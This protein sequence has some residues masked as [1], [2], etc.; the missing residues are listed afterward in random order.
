MASRGGRAVA[1]AAAMLLV[2]GACRESKSEDVSSPY[3]GDDVVLSKPELKV[4]PDGSWLLSA[5]F[6]WRTCGER[7]CWF[8]D[9]GRHGG[10]DVFG[11]YL[12]SPPVTV[13]SATLTLR[14][15]CRQETRLGVDKA[16]TGEAGAFF[17]VQDQTGGTCDGAGHE[18]NMASGAVE[19]LVRPVPGAP[20][21]GALSVT[22]LFAHSWGDTGRD[23]K[24]NAGK[25]P[26][27]KRVDWGDDAVHQ[28][29]TVGNASGLYDCSGAPQ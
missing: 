12:D 19:A 23:V 18:F 1:L 29:Q 4:V 24:V 21:A 26:D 3:S 7:A 15:S 2:T 5:S 14:S 27:G 9:K 25:P 11:V 8:H 13:Q 10:P 6:S 20:C 17:L 28:F 22:P 16:V